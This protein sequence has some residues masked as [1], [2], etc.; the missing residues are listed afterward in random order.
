MFVQPPLCS[1]ASQGGCGQLPWEV[2]FAVLGDVVPA[3]AALYE[4]LVVGRK[5]LG[6]RVQMDT[7]ATGAVHSD[8]AGALQQLR[9]V[10]DD[11]ARTAP[12][13]VLPRIENNGA[14]LID[15]SDYAVPADDKIGRSRWRN[16]RSLR[17][18]KAVS[19]DIRRD[20]A[21]ICFLM[22]I[23]LAQLTLSLRDDTVPLKC[24]TGTLTFVGSTAFKPVLLEA[25]D[26]YKNTCPGAGF[27]IDTQ[28]SVAGVRKLDE[29]G[30]ASGSS[31]PDLLAF[32]DGPRVTAIR[33]CCPAPSPSPSS[34]SLSTRMRVSRTFPWSKSGSSTREISQLDGGGRVR[35]AG[36]SR[37]PGPR[38]RHP[39]D[40]SSN[41]SLAAS[42]SPG[43]TPMT[44]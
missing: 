43:A 38:L 40:P 33:D 10:E 34:R 35:Q 14:T 27:V 21:L 3:I 31:S 28:G 5:R 17:V 15:I 44:A 13:F 22:L 24:A 23:I 6:Y 7:P 9:Q 4:F 30:K 37:Q 8:H 26:A 32:S 36:P 42:G 41:M 20:I 1:P 39:E 11:E 25:A 12:S 18:S 16:P 19:Y 29:V 2:A